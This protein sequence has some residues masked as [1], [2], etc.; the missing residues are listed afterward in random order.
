MNF[1]LIVTVHKSIL[2]FF[3]TQNGQAQC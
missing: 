2:L 1:D 3:N